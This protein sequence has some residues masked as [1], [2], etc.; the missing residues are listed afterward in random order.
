[1]AGNCFCWLWTWI[2]IMILP[3]CFLFSTG[4]RIPCVP[5]LSNTTEEYRND[6]QAEVMLFLQHCNDHETMDTADVA[7]NV[8]YYFDRFN[9]DVQIT[10]IPLSR[11][12]HPLLLY[13]CIS[14]Q[15]FTHYP[16]VFSDYLIIGTQ[17]TGDTVPFSFSSL[18]R[19]KNPGPR[20]SVTCT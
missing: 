4:E 19:K 11:E 12:Y 1:M 6:T 3:G 14:I 2:S 7:E 17:R 20:C 13:P 5:Y 8:Q 10:V 16:S 18:M 9:F 15:L